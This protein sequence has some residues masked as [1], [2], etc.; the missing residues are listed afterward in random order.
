MQL[1]AAFN[2]PK[3]N[4]TAMPTNYEIFCLINGLSGDDVSTVSVTQ[5]QT[6]E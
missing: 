5:R 6:T 2:M 4:Y 3:P 1:N